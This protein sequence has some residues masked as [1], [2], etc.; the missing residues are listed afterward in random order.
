ML[1]DT[2]EPKEAKF[3]KTPKDLHW[4][5]VG[6]PDGK[7]ASNPKALSY[8]KGFVASYLKNHCVSIQL[9]PLSQE[10]LPSIV[11]SQ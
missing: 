1:P 7:E 11:P 5:Q 8:S 9:G 6:E 3:F 4:Y 10:S 2:W